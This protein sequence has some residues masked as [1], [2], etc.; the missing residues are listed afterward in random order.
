MTIGECKQFFY[1]L[2]VT[3]LR[4]FCCL[5]FRKNVAKAC[6]LLPA[7]KSLGISQVYSLV[8]FHHSGVGHIHGSLEG[9]RGLSF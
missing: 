1:E 8:Y 4:T 5:Y 6:L 7:L 3:V 2:E 9:E